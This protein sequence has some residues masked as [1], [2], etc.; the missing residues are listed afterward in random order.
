MSLE[1]SLLE[2]V[3]LEPLLL[4]PLSRIVLR[5]F[6]VAKASVYSSMIVVPLVKAGTQHQMPY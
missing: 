6:V 4:E 5:N 1:L 2:T 3:L